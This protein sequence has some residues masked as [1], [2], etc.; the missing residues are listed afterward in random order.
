MIMMMMGLNPGLL[1]CALYVFLFE[2]SVGC[3]DDFISC[4]CGVGSG[5]FVPI[6]IDSNCDVVLLVVF[7][8]IGFES[9]GG[10]LIELFWHPKY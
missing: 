8:P 5:M 1:V 2:A 7:V 9:K 3:F 4:V 6:V 10:H